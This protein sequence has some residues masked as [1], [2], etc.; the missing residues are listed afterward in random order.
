MSS[1]FLAVP[2]KAT[3][4]VDLVKPLAHYIETMCEI[5]DDIKAE[6]KEAVQEL[7]KLRN[8]A[9]IQPLD[10][11]QSALDVVTRYYDQLVAIES[12]LPI[13]ATQNPIS[14]KWKD[15]FDKGLLF[16]GRASLTLNES[17]FE[18]AAVLFNCGALMSAIAAN[19][20]LNTDEELKTSA[21]H[22]QQSAGV[23]LA[24][25]DTVLGLVHQDPTHDLLPDT[26]ALLSTI[27]LAQAQES[28]YI[29]ADKDKM[30]AAALAKI[31]VG[32]SDFYQ[33]A[34]KQLHRDS[35][36]GLFEKEWTNM[37]TGKYFAFKAF[38]QYNEGTV[39]LNASDIGDALCRLNEA[40]NLAN[41]AASY[42]PSS[43]YSSQFAT[44]TKA[45]Q[46]A[47]KDN[48]FIYHA[49]ISDI[50]S[51]PAVPKAVLVK[52][53]PVKYPMTSHF[54]DM[55]SS[56]VPIQVHQALASYDARKAEIINLETSRLREHTQIMNGILASLNLPAAL[57]DAV[58]H[59]D[60]PES[61]RQKST[62]VKIAGGID[63]LTSLVAD[64]PNL[65][66]RNQ[67]LL[68][69]TVRLL[70]EE[71]EGDDHLR[72]QFKEK[73]TR[74]SSEKLTEPLHQECGKYRA[75][76]HSASNADEVVRQKMEE[77]REA[78]RILSLPEPELKSSIPGLDPTTSNK[79]SPTVVKLR[80]LMEK[81]EREQLEKEFSSVRT[82]MSNE[83]LKALTDNQII[84]EEQI[85]KQKLN[86]IY[87]PLKKKVEE[88][89]SKQENCLRWNKEFSS[90]KAGSVKA[91]EREKILK[92]L[93]N[94]HDKYLEIKSNLE[95]GTKF[96]ND[97][98][99]LLIR[100]QQKV[101]DF[102]FARQTEKEDLMK[103]LQQNIVSGSTNS[104]APPRPPPPKSQ[105]TATNPFDVEAPIPSPRNISN[106]QGV[107]FMYF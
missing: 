88:S 54:K 75:I 13:T 84:N 27:M 104:T 21:K 6:M 60:L 97:L 42:L 72:K 11:H 105:Q 36:K 3:N 43:L 103:Q 71:K 89:I 5:S 41:Q 74:M 91:A 48:D 73:W 77:A 95:E 79:D 15:A 83:F 50:Q 17:S 53:L 18:R 25:K 30:K 102:C 2:L 76:L 101:S 99:P 96:Y 85:S 94:G 58:S 22:F 67:E 14:F 51:L 70:K 35:V 55:F 61:I 63:L 37:I 69:E 90:E 106:L 64:L 81:V 34:Q 29:K 78:M 92:L 10:K 52:P 39:C 66:K 12:K 19:Q 65:H 107:T 31:A 98:T 7:N 62:K 59:E 80:E 8:K 24:L 47:K 28:V 23:F 16:F 45:Y 32:C 33:D 1:T 87:S 46:I 68:D 49:R 4:E 57:D 44:I 93:A 86:E 56:L 9:C 26:L 82:D 20:G 38:A 40:M 100:L